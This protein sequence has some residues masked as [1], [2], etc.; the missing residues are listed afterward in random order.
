VET[1]LVSY[2]PHMESGGC[3]IVQ[4]GTILQVHHMIGLHVSGA[5][6]DCILSGSLLVISL[7]LMY[8]FT[9]LHLHHVSWKT[10]GWVHLYMK[11]YTLKIQCK[12]WLCGTSW[13][14]VWHVCSRHIFRS[15]LQDWHSRWYGGCSSVSNGMLTA[16]T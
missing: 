1:I 13:K 12:E 2:C 11:S 7:M 6:N 3:S 5:W 4:W 14:E 8:V 10:L 9:P 15:D 16:T